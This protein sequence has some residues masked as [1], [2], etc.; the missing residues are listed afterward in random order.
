MYFSG[1]SGGTVLVNSSVRVR[2][3]HFETQTA[4]RNPDMVPNISVL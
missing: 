3:D 4:N 2:N 1:I